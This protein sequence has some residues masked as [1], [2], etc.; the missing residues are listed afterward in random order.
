MD[1]LYACPFCRELYQQGEVEVCPECDIP[2]KPLTELPLSPE[3]QALEE[4]IVPPEHESFSWLYAGRARGP[5]VVVALCGIGAF[6][7]PWL[8]QTAPYELHWS[9]FEFARQLPWLWAAG[10]AWPVMLAVVISRRSIHQMRGARVA[11]AFLATMVVATVVMRWARS[12]TSKLAVPRPCG[13]VRV[14][15]GHVHSRIP[16]AA[17]VRVGAALRRIPRRHAHDSRQARRRDAALGLSA[18]S[19]VHPGALESPLLDESAVGAHRDGQPPPAD[20]RPRS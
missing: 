16:R 15:L 11:V 6:F 20:H 10:V 12:F 8:N 1:Q 18:S 9:G 7:A 13:A 19:R 17:R 2:V 4:Q 5:L 14:R 3:A